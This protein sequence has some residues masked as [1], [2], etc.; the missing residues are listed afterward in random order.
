MQLINAWERKTQH[1]ENL[2]LVLLL[3]NILL[4]L[5]SH[6]G[7][8][9][10]KTESKSHIVRCFGTEVVPWQ[11]LATLCAEVVVSSTS[12]SYCWYSA[13]AVKHSPT[14]KQ[15]LYYVGKPAHPLQ[16]LAECFLFL[17]ITFLLWNVLRWWIASWSGR[18]KITYDFYLSSSQKSGA[19]ASGRNTIPL[20]VRNVAV[21]V[22]LSCV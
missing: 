22:S 9:Y 5:I 15:V 2:T 20:S 19:A 7:A 4:S 18:G 13:G 11:R 1:A 21:G 8:F 16:V 3:A 14:Y 10:C 6:S 17:F 12:L